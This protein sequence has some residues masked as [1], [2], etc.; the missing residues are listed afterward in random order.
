VN[1]NLSGQALAAVSDLA[2]IQELIARCPTAE[3]RKGLIMAA[4][5]HGAIECEQCELLIQAW[6]LETA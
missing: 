2:G 4:L 1:A 5:C 6:G 3:D